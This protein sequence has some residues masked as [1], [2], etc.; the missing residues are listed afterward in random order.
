M[1]LDFINTDTNARIIRI[2]SILLPRKEYVSEIHHY[3]AHSK[4]LNTS[5]KVLEAGLNDGFQ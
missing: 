2:F 1:I 4:R 3:M 5:K